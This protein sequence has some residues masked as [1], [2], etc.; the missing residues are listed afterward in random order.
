MADKL[1][2]RVI[3]T[4]HVE[5]EPEFGDDQQAVAEKGLNALKSN[6][7]PDDEQAFVLPDKEAK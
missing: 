6:A 1:T 3:H 2:V 4:Y 7:K 5:V